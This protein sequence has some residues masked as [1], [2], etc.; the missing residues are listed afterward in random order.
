L[1]GIDSSDEKPQLLLLFLLG[2]IP[3]HKS[4]PP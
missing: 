3:L 1:H 2:A 4:W